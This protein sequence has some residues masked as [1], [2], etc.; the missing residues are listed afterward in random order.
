M[1][2][3]ER[4]EGGLSLAAYLRSHAATVLMGIAALVFLWP[5]LRLT[6]MTS[7]L[8]MLF[9]V[10]AALVFG[11]MGLVNYLRTRAWC[12]VFQEI[13]AEPDRALARASEMD[14]PDG[15]EARVAY[16]ALEALRVQAAHEVGESQRRE[17]EHREYV[18]TWVHEVKTPLAAARLII[19]NE[20]GRV[21]HGLATELDRVDALVEQALFFARSSCVEK[22]L[23]IRS[24]EMSTLVREALK[25]RAQALVGVH[26]M[27]GM[28]GLEGVIAFADAKWVVFVLG[29]LIDNAVRY[30]REDGA[31]RI[32]FSACREDEGKANER[33]VLKVR[34][35]GCGVSAAD[36][37]RVWEKGFTGSNGR[38]HTKSTGIGLYLVRNLCQKMG[39]A[40]SLSSVEG[41]WTCVSL[42][43]PANRMHM[44]GE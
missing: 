29:Q 35:N 40:T 14:E 38:T 44:L 43:F 42:T 33:V 9:V 36:R 18:E 23:R 31:C 4:R 25:S 6:G 5:L 27:V 12:R 22:D 1:S 11:A 20:E 39:I 41:Q 7:E 17:R 30:R 37:G 16:E 10:L 8:A 21:P 19:D 32:D 26:M 34:D 15:A 3:H 24:C 2:A 13:A 28:E